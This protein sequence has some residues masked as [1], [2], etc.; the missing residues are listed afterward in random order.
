MQAGGRRDVPGAQPVRGAY[1]VAS[2][3]S[4]NASVRQDV[5][6]RLTCVIECRR[7]RGQPCFRSVVGRAGAGAVTGAQPADAR[8]GQTP[9]RFVS[10]ARV[11]KYRRSVPV[12]YP[13]LSRQSCR[14]RRRISRSPRP[15]SFCLVLLPN[16]F[17]SSIPSQYCQYNILVFSRFVYYR[18]LGSGV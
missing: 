17:L 12:A 5:C 15:S 2:S 10:A 9:F 14:A 6:G 1:T 13:G 16:D 18:F 7:E 8:T 3:T 4:S 11:V